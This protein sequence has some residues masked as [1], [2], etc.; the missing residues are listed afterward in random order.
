MLVSIYIFLKRQ[1]MKIKKIAAMLVLAFGSI[2][3]AN[4]SVSYTYVG[5]WQVDQGPSWSTT[6][7]AY[8]GQTAAA[9]IF[10]GAA[11]DY[12]ISTIDNVVA[13]IDFNAW[14]STWGGSCGGTYP[15]G[16]VVAQNFG[17]S[18]G[19]MY[20][21]FGYTSAY[22]MD[23]A[24]GAQFTNYAFLVNENNVPEPGSLALIGLGLVGI[25]AARRRKSV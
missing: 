6:P 2:G 20:D 13:N 24:V 11:T 16:T 14:V 18:S 10:G 4:A 15:C 17:V 22:V 8:T 3:A 21:N 7:V 19:G 1:I 25:A 9:L 12:A 5:S 23:W